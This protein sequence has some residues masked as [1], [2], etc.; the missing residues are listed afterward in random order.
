MPHIYI[1]IYIYIY[2]QEIDQHDVVARI[3]GAVTHGYE[4]DCG[5]ERHQLVFGWLTGLTDAINVHVYAY[6]YAYGYGYGHVYGYV[7]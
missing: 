7:F 5:H 4:N 1:Y 2:I 3:N 6:A